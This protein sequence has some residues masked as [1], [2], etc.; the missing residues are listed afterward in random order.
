MARR[1]HNRSPHP[2]R[3]PA[4][5]PSA[6]P[7]LNTSVE[8]EVPAE[9]CSTSGGEQGGAG[10][11]RAEGEASEASGAGWGGARF[12][13]GLVLLFVFGVFGGWWLSRSDEA[14]SPPYAPPPIVEAEPAPVPMEPPPTATGRLVGR[15]IGPDGAPLE[16][17]TLRLWSGRA[18]STV[19]LATCA[20]D[21]AG[22]FA[23]EG[24]EAVRHRISA[25]KAGFASQRLAGI[26]PDGEPVDLELAAGEGMFGVVTLDGAPVSGARVQIGAAGMWPPLLTLTGPDGRFESSP[27]AAGDYEL[28]VQA[29]LEDGSSAGT[30]ATV[31]HDGRADGEPFEL[32]LSPTPV[33]TLTVVDDVTGGPV[34]GAL[35]IA[36]E[37]VVHIVSAMWLSGESGEVELDGLLARPWV[38]R[39]RARGYLETVATFSPGAEGAP[40]EL[41]LAPAVTVRGRVVDERGQPAPLARL[42]ALVRTD[43]GEVEVVDR[44]AT[45]AMSA[46]AATRAGVEPSFGAIFG[47]VSDEDGAFE[48]TGIPPGRVIIEASRD[49]DQP[50]WSPAMLLAAGVIE[51]NVT[52]TLRAGHV[53]AG[54]IIGPD[55]QVIAGARVELL[56]S[57]AEDLTRGDDALHLGLGSVCIT[58]GDG[59]FRRDD[60]PQRVRLV[61][62]APGYEEGGWSGDLSEQTEPIEVR[63]GV[64]G[65]AVRGRVVDPEGIAVAGVTLR[66]APAPDAP[67]RRGDACVQ[68]T[69][70]DG[71]FLLTG[72]PE[73]DFDVR[74]D[75]PSPEIATGFARLHPGEETELRLERGGSLAVTVTDPDGQG[76]EGASVSI[77]PGAVGAVPAAAREGLAQTVRTEAGGQARVGP[78]RLGRWKVRVSRAGFVPAEASA[79]VTSTAAPAALAVR[80][81]RARTVEGAVVDR[82]SQALPGAW[83]ELRVDG[84]HLQVH[85][86]DEGGRWAFTVEHEG[87]VEVRALQ[88]DHGV[89]GWRSWGGEA[90][91]ILTLEEVAVDLAVH[92]ESLK[93][94]GAT[95][96]RDGDSILV[97]E[98]DPGGSADLAGL[99]QADQVLGVQRRGDGVQLDV[100]RGGR[101]LRV[102]VK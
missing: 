100:V 92:S 88:P 12:W 53:L 21:G 98:V 42:R 31:N 2:P 74:I 85:R 20:S 64:Q 70:P 76:V 83:V 8:A 11:D 22:Q 87:A 44:D 81:I 68:T 86:T 25:D 6:T 43:R 91:Q 32:P 59:R 95:L 77:V 96:W 82:Y 60:L 7:E 27:L 58:D 3:E 29:T 26:L 94:H 28:L 38:F 55:G 1:K 61:A 65:E 17:V 56:P 39:A 19:A 16:G 14:P 78:L 45:G 49:G 9:A 102:D 54:R 69:D 75:A 57:D 41:R 84:K 101:R 97:T 73:T 30:V 34:A 13:A 35:V 47:F 63:L 66:Y 23:F 67:A 62:T 40:T 51:E 90:E 5:A 10:A 48:V 80:L 93:E 37:D 33:F 52:L 36:A 4:A 99:R 15:V 46:L 18:P 71:R 79:E 89:S 24:L 72:C 50:A